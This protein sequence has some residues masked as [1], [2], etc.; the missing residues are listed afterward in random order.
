MRQRL[1]FFAAIAAAACLTAWS[2]NAAFADQA[3]SLPDNAAA[4]YIT[5]FT[6]TPDGSCCDACKSMIE[7]FNITPLAQVKSRMHWNHYDEHSWHMKR[8]EGTICSYPT[9]LVQSPDGQELLHQQ[10]VIAPEQCLRSVARSVRNAPNAGTVMTVPLRSNSPCLYGNCPLR[11]LEP[12]PMAENPN[13][14]IEPPVAR[15]ITPKFDAAVPVKPVTSPG[16][17]EL[18]TA[19]KATVNSALR[20]QPGT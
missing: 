9:V 20:V 13:E 17:I 6:H 7:R 15:A 18:K 5:L 11:R 3:P 14:D 16:G 8:F 12:M 10:G 1:P 4:C 2:M 19:P